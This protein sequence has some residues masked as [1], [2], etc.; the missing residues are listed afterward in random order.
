LD[1]MGL[2]LLEIG[3]AFLLLLFVLLSL[4]L[5]LFNFKKTPT[6]LI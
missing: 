3:L 1:F 2:V 5:P 4:L 6:P